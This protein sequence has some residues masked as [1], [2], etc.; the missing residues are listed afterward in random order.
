MGITGSKPTMDETEKTVRAEIDEQISNYKIFMISKK[1]CPFC[2][3]AKVRYHKMVVMN[4]MH[5]KIRELSALL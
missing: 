2:R 3:T 5:E 4:S 1:S